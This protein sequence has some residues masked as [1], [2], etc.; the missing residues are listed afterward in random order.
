MYK[1]IEPKICLVDVAGAEPLPESGKREPC[2]PCNP[3]FYNNDTATCSPCPPGTFS[4]GMKRTKNS[5]DFYCVPDCHFPSVSLFV[6]LCGNCL[7]HCVCFAAC[8][9]CPAGTEP[10]LGYEYKWWNILPTNMKT[11]CFNVGNSKC[12][13]MNGGCLYVTI[14]P[15]SLSCSSSLCDSPKEKS[16]SFA[17][18]LSVI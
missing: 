12:D 10:N 7:F 3:G 4:D 8:Q 16:C 1:W 18:L 2:P 11:S 13:N 6:W 5:V 9:Q 14:W 15:L 17:F